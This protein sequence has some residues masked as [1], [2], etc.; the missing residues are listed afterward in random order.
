MPS[1]YI[2]FH[3]HAQMPYDEKVISIPS[4]RMGVDTVSPYIPNIW[5]G[6]HPYDCDIEIDFN[7]QISPIINSVVGIGEIGLDYYYN[8]SNI[9]R[10]NN[11]FVE[12]LNFA[13]AGNLPITIHCVRGYNRLLEILK[14]YKTLPKIVLHSFISSPEMAKQFLELGCYLSFSA[15]SFAS[16]KTVEVMRCAPLERIFLE[17]DQEKIDIKELYKL[18]SQYREQSIEQIKDILYNNFKTVVQRCQIG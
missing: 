3:N 2:D 10:Q 4:Y 9:E 8:S 18:F 1:K 11:I 6:I 12:Q 13:I 15:A 7:S 17:S 14:S 16:R 5:I